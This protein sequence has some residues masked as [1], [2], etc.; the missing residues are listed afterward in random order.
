MLVF[1]IYEYWDSSVSAAQHIYNNTT[2]ERQVGSAPIQYEVPVWVQAADDEP[3][4][5]CFL[6]EACRLDAEQIQPTALQLVGQ[7]VERAEEGLKWGN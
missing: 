6:P 1:C 5:D 2:H 7:P 3:G 4:M